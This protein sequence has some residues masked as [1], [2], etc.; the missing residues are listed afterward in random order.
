[1]EALA[2]VG[3]PLML[4]CGIAC[5]LSLVVRFRRSRGVERQQL[6]WF[7]YAAA[8]T[9]AGVLVTEVAPSPRGRHWTAWSSWPAWP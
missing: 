1:V 2:A 5:M 8:V 3:F 7:V 6:K 4:A 9:F